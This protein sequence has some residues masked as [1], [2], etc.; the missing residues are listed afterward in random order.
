MEQTDLI[1]RAARL[2]NLAS[3]RNASGFP[4]QAGAR[5]LEL[6]ELLNA[7]LEPEAAASEQKDD[8]TKT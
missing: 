5:L 3:E 4:D 1:N 8:A 2:I 7:Q 6:R